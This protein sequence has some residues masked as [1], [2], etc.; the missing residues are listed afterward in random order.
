[1][2]NL[3]VVPFRLA[4]DGWET[5]PAHP[6]EC[7]P[8]CASADRLRDELGYVGYGLHLARMAETRD[9]RQCRGCGRWGLWSLRALPAAPPCPCCSAAPYTVNDCA[10]REDCGA[11]WCQAVED[12]PDIEPGVMYVRPVTGGKWRRLGR[13][14]ME[15]D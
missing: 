14:A 5:V 12:L 8:A 3:S 11:V 1:M 2:G 4:P 7:E 10:C 9:E 15:G 6:R 13:V